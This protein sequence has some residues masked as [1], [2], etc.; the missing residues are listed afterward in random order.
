MLPTHTQ[1]PSTHRGL[2]DSSANRV[3]VQHRMD[4]LHAVDDLRHAQIY[5]KAGE[6]ERGLPGDVIRRLHVIQHGVERD[7][8]GLIQ[9]F[10]EA[11]G[12]VS[13]GGFGVRCGDVYLRHE[14]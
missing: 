9:A 6:T 2:F 14:C 5:D 11:E 10:V 4:A 7:V 12:H 13:I 1:A 3:I 8:L